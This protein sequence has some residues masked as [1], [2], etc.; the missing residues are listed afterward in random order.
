MNY[1]SNNST[2]FTTSCNTRKKRLKP[3]EEFF[4]PIVHLR[5]GLFVGDM[6][7]RLGISTSSI[8]RIIISWVSYMYLKLIHARFHEKKNTQI[9]NEL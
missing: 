3:E 9:Y 8:T 6:A 1:I 2:V 5:V 4:I 7:V